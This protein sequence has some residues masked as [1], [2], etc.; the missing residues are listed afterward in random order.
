MKSMREKWFG[1]NELFG[2]EY[3]ECGVHVDHPLVTE[4]RET[5]EG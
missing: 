1:K 5:E 3:V 2:Y 4:T